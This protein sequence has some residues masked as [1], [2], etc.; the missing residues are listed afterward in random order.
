MRVYVD[1]NVLIDVIA[2]R[3]PFYDDSAA[4]WTLSEQGQIT[5]LVSA[6]SFNNIYYV[7]RRLEDSRKARRALELLR[8]TFQFVAC[9][10]QVLNQA[11]GAKFKDFEDAVQYVSAIRASADCLVSRNPAHF[12]TAKDC[13]VLSPKEFL[14]TYR[15]P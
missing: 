10:Q 3:Q 5:G 6:I 12:P 9:D 2:K 13:P 8:D 4:I 7:V 15:Q 14:A 11:I 1:T